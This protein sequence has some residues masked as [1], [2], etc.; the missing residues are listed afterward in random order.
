MGAIEFL[1]RHG[2]TVVAVDPDPCDEGEVVVIEDAPAKPSRPRRGK[3]N[4][5]TTTEGG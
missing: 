2:Y 1:R 3:P 4:D 5:T